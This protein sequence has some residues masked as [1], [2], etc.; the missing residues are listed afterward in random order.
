MY[1][2]VFVLIMNINDYKILQTLY[3]YGVLQRRQILIYALVSENEFLESTQNLI[4]M[5]YV[6]SIDNNYY[7]I[8]VYGDAY[9]Q[10]E[11]DEYNFCNRN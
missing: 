1:G 3:K 9:M 7:N 6:A 5:N 8:T 11:Q 10:E 4:K 2:G